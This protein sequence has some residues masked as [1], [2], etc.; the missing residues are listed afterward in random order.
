LTRG[1]HQS[2]I[3]ILYNSLL[4]NLGQKF[5]QEF[6]C[7]FFLLVLYFLFLQ[8]RFFFFFLYIVSPSLFASAFFVTLFRR[9]CSLVPFLSLYWCCYF[10]ASV[11]HSL[12]WCRVV[13]LQ[14]AGALSCCIISSRCVGFAYYIVSCAVSS[15]C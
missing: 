10:V 14:F 7:L 5:G 4:R 11:L 13:M 6:L 1:N 15:Y 8:I 3:S 2:R 12:V 9:R